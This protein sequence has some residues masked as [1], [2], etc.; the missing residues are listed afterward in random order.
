[1]KEG[2]KCRIHLRENR[3]KIQ[4]FTQSQFRKPLKTTEWLNFFIYQ[5]KLENRR[6]YQPKKGERKEDTNQP[7][8][9]AF[10]PSYPFIS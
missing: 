4:N 5:Q 3:S 2:R 7:L 8:N 6:K 10:H 1:M 9:W